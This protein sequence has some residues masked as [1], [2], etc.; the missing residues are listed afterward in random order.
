MA[1]AKITKRP[2][3]LE[4]KLKQKTKMPLH[5]TS[6]TRRI[7]DIFIVITDLVR[8]QRIR[9]KTMTKKDV[10][11]LL[12]VQLFK[13]NPE[14]KDFLTQLESENKDA[15]KNLVSAIEERIDE[16]LGKL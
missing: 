15:Y 16:E 8:E 2:E 13:K 11:T 14:L 10:K 4:K 5:M 9:L 3:R 1:V 7:A 6:T 12:I